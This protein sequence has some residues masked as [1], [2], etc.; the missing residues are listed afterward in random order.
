MQSPSPVTN[1][2]YNHKNAEQIGG[3][4]YNGLVGNITNHMLRLLKLFIDNISCLG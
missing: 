1:I 2:A 3:G 4:C